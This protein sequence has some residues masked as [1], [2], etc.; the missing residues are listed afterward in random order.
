MNVGWSATQSGHSHQESSRQSWPTDLSC[1]SGMGSALLSPLYSVTG[2][3]SPREGSLGANTDM[4]FQAGSLVSH[5][6]C[7]R[8]WAKHIVMAPTMCTCP[9][10]RWVDKKI[11][12]RMARKENI[13]MLHGKLSSTTQITSSCP[14]RLIPVQLYQVFPLAVKLGLVAIH[15]HLSG[16]FN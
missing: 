1:L 10:S 7:S 11:K 6:V 8:R 3:N 14:L 12:D 4:D 15:W 13:S 9:A 5:P 2:W 16:L